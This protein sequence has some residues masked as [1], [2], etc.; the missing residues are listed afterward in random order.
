MWRENW[1]EGSG[2]RPGPQLF[3]EPQHC[4]AGRM[5]QKNRAEL[6]KSETNREH[7]DAVK[8]LWADEKAYEII[9]PT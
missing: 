5:F 4:R 3:C 7:Y 8:E 1:K 9:S 6:I 2:V